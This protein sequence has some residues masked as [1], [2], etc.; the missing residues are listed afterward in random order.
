[1]DEW[2]RTI[3]DIDINDYIIRQ[4]MVNN[5]RHQR[6]YH[7]DHWGQGQLKRDYRKVISR[8]FS[9]RCQPSR[10]CR[11]VVSVDIGIM[12]TDQ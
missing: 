7:F 3:S 12:N 8:D 1:M 6:V 4:A 11:G 5:P 9:R 2:I 10:L